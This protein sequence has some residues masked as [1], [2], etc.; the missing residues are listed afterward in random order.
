MNLLDQT[1]LKTKTQRGNCIAA[2]FSTL[3]NLDNAESCFQIQEHFDNG[4]DQAWDKMQ[5]FLLAHNYYYQSIK[6]HLNDPRIY[7]VSGTGSR[8]VSHMCLYRNGKLL[9]DPHP[10]RHGLIT[11]KHF[12]ILSPNIGSNKTETHVS[13]YYMSDGMLSVCEA[14]RIT[15][16]EWWI[17]RVKLNDKHKNRGLGSHLLQD[18]LMEMKWQGGKRAVVFPGGYNEDPLKQKLFY[19]RNGFTGTDKLILE[20]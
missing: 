16:D 9:H 8:D 11:E 18:A 12:S 17:A 7:L 13:T 5:D 6:G 3:L 4:M 2:C 14:D 19:I 1:R 20:F 10:S 15:E